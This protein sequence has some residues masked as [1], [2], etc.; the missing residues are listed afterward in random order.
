MRVTAVIPARHASTRFP[1]KPLADIHGKPMI[2]W[3]YE[4][5]RQSNGVHRVIVATEDE[6][7]AAVVESFGARCR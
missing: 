1:G 4:R 3:V 2:Q 5:T 6:R 7:I